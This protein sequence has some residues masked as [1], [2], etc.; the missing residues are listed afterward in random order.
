[1][2][3]D[4]LGGNSH[5]A[6]IATIGPIRYNAHETLSTLMFAARCMDVQT[7][8]TVNAVVDYRQLAEELRTALTAAEQVR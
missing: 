4:A 8:A 3:T 7:R 2:L 6:L 5:T 1:L